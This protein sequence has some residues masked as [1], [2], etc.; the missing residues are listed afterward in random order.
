MSTNEQATAMKVC[1][2]ENHTEYGRSVTDR[3]E[4]KSLEY[5]IEN[6]T[7]RKAVDPDNL[8]VVELERAAA[9]LL[10]VNISLKMQKIS[11][12]SEADRKACIKRDNKAAM[13]IITSGVSSGPLGDRSE[14]EE[15]KSA[16][17]SMQVL[18]GLYGARDTYAKAARLS[19]FNEIK[20]GKTDVIE[21]MKKKM[22]SFS[23][24]TASGGMMT[25]IQFLSSLLM[26]LGPTRYKDE[27]K[28][29][30]RQLD[31]GV[32]PAWADVRNAFMRAKKDE[33]RGDQASDS[34]TDEKTQPSAQITRVGNNTSNNQFTTQFTA[35]MEDAA[36]NIVQNAM[37]TSFQ[38]D[39]GGGGNNRFGN[40]DARGGGNNRFGGGGNYGGQGGDRGGNSR[41]GGG[42]GG[43]GKGGGWQ[44]G[45]G[46]GG[47]SNIKCYCCGKMG[48]MAAECRQR[49]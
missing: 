22:F 39:G 41:R 49:Y 3:L 10:G 4:A 40:N 35:M 44:G 19:E 36:Q 47:G 43:G 13:L 14:F 27:R 21:Y 24:Y 45:G 23:R 15:S 33:D 46:K 34:E 42:K 26:E 48:H 9:I 16:Y 32:T 29:I 17:A 31:A 20:L 8:T 12:A 5:V 6:D 1:N 30:M 38:N 2:E 25:K 11:G 37:A 28:D 7:E 18:H